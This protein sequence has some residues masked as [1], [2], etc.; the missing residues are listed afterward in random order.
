[1]GAIMSLKF[2]RTDH[3]DLTKADACRFCRPA[4]SLSI[5]DNK[6]LACHASRPT[7]STIFYFKFGRMMQKVEMNTCYRYVTISCRVKATNAQLRRAFTD[8]LCL[9]AM[10]LAAHLLPRQA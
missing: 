5:T 9:L 2:A 3:I 8:P 4:C 6:F 7:G 1:M 10:A